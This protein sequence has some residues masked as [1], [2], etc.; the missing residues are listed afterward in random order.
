M[1]E[2][3]GQGAYSFKVKSMVEQKKY[4]LIVDLNDVRK[5]QPELARGY[6]KL[7]FVLEY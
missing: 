4:R 1:L 5:A 2:Q 3:L 7:K 6:V